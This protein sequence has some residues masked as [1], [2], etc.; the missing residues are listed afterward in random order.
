MAREAI[1]SAAPQDDRPLTGSPKKWLWRVFIALVTVM[2]LSEVILRYGV[3]LGDPPLAQL[4]PETEYELVPSRSYSR[5]GN[6]IYI[7]R[8]GLR[9]PEHEAVASQGR[10]HVLLIGDSV[11]Y[12]GHF[13]DQ[14]ET[15]SA[16]LTRQLSQQPQFEGCN[17]LALPMAVSS[18]GPENQAAFLARSGTFGARVVGL[19]VSAHDLYDVPNTPSDII[20]YRTHAP[21]SALAD[22]VEAIRERLVHKALSRPE[23]PIEE[24]R[25]RSLAALEEIVVRMQSENTPFFLAYHSTTSEFGGNRSLEFEVFQ[26]WALE[27][28][29]PF[30]DM[31]PAANN[32]GFYR[33]TIHPTA[34][35]A[36][37]ISEKL[38]IATAPYLDEDC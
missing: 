30:L 16:Q 15:I 4:D 38:R 7:N 19:V 12:G 3:G 25:Q 24:R 11:V 37:F 31:L 27:R 2:V 18:W 34:L 9:A 17:I 10:Q 33:D 36:A 23:L 32:S 35:G 14:A 20:P 8:F 21:W 26:E 29:I 5:W 22:L 28:D 1:A 13:L 6:E